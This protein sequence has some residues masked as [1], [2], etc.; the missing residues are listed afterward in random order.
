MEAAA[1]PDIWVL[2]LIGE[3]KPVPVVATPYAE[4]QARFSPDGRWLAYF[5]NETGQSEVNV[6]PFPGPGQ[7]IRVSSSGGVEPRWRGDGKELY[8]LQDRT[9]VAV[10]IDVEVDRLRLGAARVLFEL[11]TAGTT[12]GNYAVTADGQRFLVNTAGLGAA[13]HGEVVVVMDW[14]SRLTR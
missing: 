3:R 2:P 11:P 7:K 8:Y 4:G 10:E 5:S 12:R 13:P 6:I 9:M 14:S 1:T